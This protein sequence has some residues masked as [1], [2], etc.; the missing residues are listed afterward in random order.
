MS[1]A[2]ATLM[3]GAAAAQAQ[4]LVGLTSA[5]ELARFDVSNP[6]M[7]ER[8]AIT[9][10]A[11]GDRL[12][13][14]DLRPT[15]GLLYG[16]SLS[17][18]IYTLD[19]STGVATFVAALSV[20]VISADRGWGI[21]FNP[22]RDFAGATSLRVVSTAGD[23]LAVNASTGAVANVGN[24]IAPGFSS[25]AYS[26]SVPGAAV[27]PATTALYYI[28]SLNDTLSFAGGAFN[29][30]TITTIGP[31]GIDVL[32]AG[33]FELTAANIGFAAL[34]TD[35]SGLNTGL[36]QIDLSTGMAQWRGDFNGTLT[37]LTVSAVPEPA[38]LA[39]LAG[40]LGALAWRR[41]HATGRAA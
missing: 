14:I 33:G 12:V 22:E 7:A 27:G 8:V 30:P 19:E 2:A 4:L 13:G 39:L 24:L 25:V 41:R 9:G 26:N 37:G 40:G 34:N 10:L 1:L 3:L 17:N 38:S 32:R 31:L 5:N 23:N 16:I 6:G 28:N 20:P 15:N 21:D 18:R 35:G 36:Y 11:A 29:T